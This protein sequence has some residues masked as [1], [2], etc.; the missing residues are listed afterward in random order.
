[1]G[2]GG[3]KI[4][5]CTLY[6]WYFSKLVSPFVIKDLNK[7]WESLCFVWNCIKGWCCLGW[8]WLW[9]FC[10]FMSA[11]FFFS[12][13]CQL[14]RPRV[15]LLIKG[16]PGEPV[17]WLAI[18]IRIWTERSR[19]FLHGPHH[20][21]PCSDFAPAWLFSFPWCFWDITV[22]ISKLCSFSLGG[23]VRWLHFRASLQLDWGL[24]LSFGQW[25]LG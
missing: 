10:Q 8:R 15:N 7:L 3:G 9:N 2:L 24:W 1:M 25:S 23:Y 18:G 19:T 14:I 21:S 5:F 11:F 13:S 12:L 16:E 4:S 6:I 22:S 17:Y 20:N